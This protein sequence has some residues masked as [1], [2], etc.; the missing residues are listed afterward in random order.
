MEQLLRDDDIIIDRA[1]LWHTEQKRAEEENFQQIS[2]R[3][4]RNF[5]YLKAIGAIGEIA[6]LSERK[7]ERVPGKPRGRR[8][9]AYLLW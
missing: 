7:V 5:A 1:C 3:L 2:R 4:G 8:R 9:L 6:N